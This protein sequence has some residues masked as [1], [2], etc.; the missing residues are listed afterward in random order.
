MQCAGCEAEVEA[1]S[2]FCPYCGLPMAAADPIEELERLIQSTREEA[3]SFLSRLEQVQKRFESIKRSDRGPYTQEEPPVEPIT[4]DPLSAEGAVPPEVAGE[5]H[6][7]GVG[8]AAE[9]TRSAPASLPEK[10][11][12]VSWFFRSGSAKT[13]KPGFSEAQLGQKWLL[14]VGIIVMVLGIGY[15]LKYSFDRNWIGPAG[16]VAMSYAAGMACLAGGEITRRRLARMFGLYLSGG[17]IAVLYFSTFAAF[18]I[19]SLLIQPAAF[20]IMIMVTTLACSLAL[21]YDTK[22]LAVLGLIGGFL[23]P[24]ILSTGVDNQL[25][26]MTYMVVLNCGILTIAFFK[27]W[28]LLNHLGL[29]FTWLLFSAWYFRWY[30]EDPDV[31]KFWSTIIF[32]NIFFLIYAVAPFVFYFVKERSEKL[33]G[34]ALTVPNAFVALGFSYVIISEYFSR[35]AVSV[36]TIAYTTVFALMANYLYRKYSENLEPFIL[37]LAKAL[38]FLVVTVP[39]LFSDQWITIFWV[40]QAI[41]ITWAALRLKNRWLYIGGMVLL[42]GAAAKFLFYDYLEVF[43][44]RNYYS[45]LNYN[46]MIVGRWLTSAVVLVG[47]F[48][49]AR[50]PKEPGIS[51]RKLLHYDTQVL[52]I[53]FA[54]LLFIVLNLEVSGFFYKYAGQARFASISILWAL[55]SSGL[56]ALGFVK[57]KSVLRRVSIALFAITVAKV[58][59]V[60]MSNVST[61]FRIV[62][63]IV[64]GVLLIGVSFLYH[65]HKDL[66]LPDEEAAEKEG[67]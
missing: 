42:A 30:F 55:Y 16:R 50:F 20:G 7:E 65:R 54:L 47:L 43:N 41:G 17:G 56:M 32:L 22:W 6:A 18:Q 61:P 57:R 45:F 5:I 31:S 40:I 25:A 12:G 60:D 28:A 38:I 39:M 8:D 13:W 67:E 29:A 59:L 34:F 48:I 33:A 14:I 53:C 2:S 64:L 15:F 23:T 1:G 58:F 63:F 3:V 24:V 11:S 44:L 46:D 26:L 62:S 36:L 35:P 52:Y 9:P 27:R 19:Y 66:F 4:A 10:R 51:G 49:L 37:L 21:F